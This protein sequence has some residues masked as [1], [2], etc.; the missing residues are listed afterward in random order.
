MKTLKYM[1]TIQ[2]AP[3]TAV[4]TCVVKGQ[5]HHYQPNVEYELHLTAVDDRVPSDRQKMAATRLAAIDPENKP[6]GPDYLDIF[7]SQRS[8]PSNTAALREATTAEHLQVFTDYCDELSL[9]LGQRA[10]A[11]QSTQSDTGVLLI[12]G[13]PG[14]GKTK[15]LLAILL[16]HAS[17]GRPVIFASGQNQPVL[18]AAHDLD[19]YIREHPECP[20][21]ATDYVVFE[22][23]YHKVEKAKSLLARQ[24]LSK[25]G[26]GDGQEEAQASSCPGYTAADLEE[27]A[28]EFQEMLADIFRMDVLKGKS[29]KRIQNTV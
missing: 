9:N 6:E 25:Q 13:P 24:T 10:A 28:L 16:A 17:V 27:D 3:T 26:E 19:E 21:E 20:I 11:T 23:A 22:G 12:Q 1:G 14:T 15:T 2:R 5:K 18:K 7:F 29:E 4:Y 8:P